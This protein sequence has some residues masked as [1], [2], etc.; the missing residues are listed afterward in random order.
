M[1]C[2]FVFRVNFAHFPIDDAGLDL[3]LP[4]GRFESFYFFGNLEL[5]GSHASQFDDPFHG[6]PF[7]IVYEGD[8][9]ARVV[10]PTC[11]SDSVNIIVGVAGDRK[12]DDTIGLWHVDA[13]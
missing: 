11:S 4:F 10:R 12:V 5:L 2:S 1:E 7:A 6:I 3:L 13:S 9:F 8:G